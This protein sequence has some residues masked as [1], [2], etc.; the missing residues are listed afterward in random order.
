MSRNACVLDL[1]LAVWRQ[2][3]SRTG[4]FKKAQWLSL[5]NTLESQCCLKKGNW[6]KHYDE[7]RS[8]KE[9]ID[10]QNFPIADCI[11]VAKKLGW[12][13]KSPPI[14]K[15]SVRLWVSLVKKHETT[16]FL[17]DLPLSATNGVASRKIEGG[18]NFNFRRATVFCLGYRL[19]KHEITR[20]AKI[21]GVMAPWLRL[22]LQPVCSRTLLPAIDYSQD[23]HNKNKSLYSFAKKRWPPSACSPRN[24]NRRPSAWSVPVERF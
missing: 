15:V 8:R 1:I 2:L 6:K 11:S 23:Q 16:R 3:I 9:R 7:E 21:W 17:K 22:C 13:E 20:Y 14:A 18:K 12:I 24:G 19:S 5:N 10:P 4:R